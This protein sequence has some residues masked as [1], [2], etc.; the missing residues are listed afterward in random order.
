MA[1]YKKIL[2]NL[3]AP[4]LLEL[5][6]LVQ[7]QS[8]STLIQ[9]AVTYSEQ[10]MIPLWKKY[11]PDDPRPMEA[12][13]AARLWVKGVIKL[14]T[15]KTVILYC[16]KAAREVE[17]NLVAQGAARAIAHSASTIHSA[18]HSIGLVLYGALAI[19]YDQLGINAPWDELERK[20]AQECEKMLIALKQISKDER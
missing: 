12:L 5:R 2:S 18:R 3:D 7:S 17:G 13:E 11:H 8:K 19:A 15:A 9:W 4:Y 14:P 10:V 6:E 1:I 20:A 16:H